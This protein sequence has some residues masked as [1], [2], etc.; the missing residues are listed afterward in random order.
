M[1]GSAIDLACE[2]VGTDKI[3]TVL[4]DAGRA[5]AESGAC[6]LGVCKARGVTCEPDFLCRPCTHCVYGEARDGLRRYVKRALCCQVFG[7]FVID[8]DCNVFAYR[9]CKCRR[10]RC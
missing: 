2:Q 3:P 7:C 8:C 6:C 4:L 5:G 1:G 9:T 10:Y